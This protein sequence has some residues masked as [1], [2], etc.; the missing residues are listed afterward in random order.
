[1]AMVL[2]VG[3]G[4]SDA[5]EGYSY[6]DYADKFNSYYSGKTA[7]GS[8]RIKIGSEE[9]KLKGNLT[10]V[11][12]YYA[13]TMVSYQGAGGSFTVYDSFGARG[14]LSNSGE[15]FKL[16]SWTSRTTDLADMPDLSEYVEY[17]NG[18]PKKDADGHY[19]FKS[20]EAKAAYIKAM[21]DYLISI[22]FTKE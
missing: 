1:M 2:S 14:T 17:E 21:T 8:V 20:D 19:V 5:F 16:T 18:Q 3:L 13:G 6:T 22:G 11:F 4:V 15:Q 10:G 7:S 12:G 9:D